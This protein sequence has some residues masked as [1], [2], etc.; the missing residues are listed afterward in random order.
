M[1][2]D[3]VDDFELAL[4]EVETVVKAFDDKAS[5]EATSQAEKN[6]ALY[7][8]LDKAF[9]FHKAWSDKPE[10]AALLEKKK[11]KATTRG[12]KS[13]P[14]T[15]T[16]KAFFDPQWDAF[17]P[18]D[19]PE[20]ADKARRQKCISTYSA[21]L[22]YAGNEGA[23][24][25]AAF[26]VSKKGI[27][28][29]RVAWKEE[30]AKTPEAKTRKDK[31]KET[32]EKKLENG[33]AALQ[34][35]M[36]PAVPSSTK[37]KGTA[38]LAAIFFDDAGVAHFLGFPQD[39]DSSKALLEKFLLSQGQSPAK[40]AGKRGRKAGATATSPQN[41]TNLNKLLRLLSVG[42]IA[43][44]NDANVIIINDSKGCEIRSSHGSH[45]TCMVHAKLPHQDFLSDGTYWFGAKAIAGMAKLAVLGKHGAQFT[46]N[47]PSKIDGIDASVE[48]TITDYQAGVAA[49]TKRTPDQPWDWRG[50]IP[51][52]DIR[53]FAE[54]DGVATITYISTIEKM[55]RIKLINAWDGEAKVDGDF[56]AWLQSTL[57]ISKKDTN[58]RLVK[59]ISDGTRKT[60]MFRI[61]NKDWTVLDGK[62]DVIA[63]TFASPIGNSSFTTEFTAGSG[64]ILSAI[65]AVN[66][67]VDGGNTT[68]SLVNKL[69]RVQ[70]KKGGITAEVFI[71][72][73]G[74]DGR[75]QAYTEYDLQLKG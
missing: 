75:H 42:K 1:S 45:D 61:T 29:A 67:L 21:V 49:I 19:E 53:R 55:A 15:P 30:R 68:I 20:K 24:D 57:G 69:M 33:L 62:G 63:H 66:A 22:D 34:K 35:G 41:S 31:A 47:G 16:I 59:A 23:N 17:T 56:A 51:H 70:C 3:V 54:K 11:V 26:I 71:P 36:L 5:A 8:A 48:I 74:T 39:D 7:A 2:A 25:V 12:A 40:T 43:H 50:V 9:K 27:E 14:F 32:R 46:I 65:D 38:C 4:T 60:T 28:A 73:I 13:S 58:T 52:T 72:S 64:E 6:A 18:R 10:F 44:P 37:L